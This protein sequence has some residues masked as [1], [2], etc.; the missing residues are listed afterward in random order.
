MDINRSINKL[1]KYGIQ[2]EILLEEDKV[3]AINQLLNL[4]QLEEY[5]EE[6]IVEE[7]F[8]E[9]ILKEI[10]DYSVENKIIEEDTVTRRDL[11][12]TKV[13]NIIMPRPSQ[14]IKKFNEEYE[15][16]SKNATDYYFKFSRATDY[17]RTYR[18]KKDLK[19]KT[20][21]KYGALDI[22]IN[23]SKPEKDPK[24]I[25][26]A[27]QMKKVSYPKCVL[28]KETEG[29]KGNLSAASRDNHRIIPITLNNEK[30][31]FQYSPY[32]YY[33][34]HC[35]I[36]NSQHTP[37][38]IDKTTFIKLFDFVKMFPHYMIG[39]NAGLPVV[40]GS[41]LTHEHYQGGRQSFPMD[42]A[43]VRYK[44]KIKDFE[45][46]EFEVLNW[47]LSAIRIR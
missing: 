8:L 13:M 22:T 24:D 10:L 2:N 46:I 1:V 33:N 15:K 19:W 40:G 26:L 23:L 37:M 12:D 34:E 36:L 25:A 6:E 17:I 11:F 44:T 38:K 9:D 42:N 47:P 16:S 41:I 5:T 21:T 28:C 43:K 3:Y 27:K 7:L 35:I 20:D 30:W 4:L 45:D 14:V 32:C 39:S 31:Y 18:V 29:F